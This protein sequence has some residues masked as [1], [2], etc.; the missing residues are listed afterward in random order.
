[1][2]LRLE[3]SY[4]GHDGIVG[5]LVNNELDDFCV[6]LEHAYDSGHGDGSYCPKLP[7]G[8]YECQLG[9]HRLHDGIPF[10][11]YEIL[12]VTGHDNILFHAGNYNKDS[13]GCV[14]V[15]EKQVLQQNGDIMVTNSRETFK[16]FM[17]YLKNV[18][19][20]TLIVVDLK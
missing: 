17:E 12:G 20:F 4:F 19:K 3:R 1:M 8:T 7:E 9:T 10:Q 18:E 16:K 15:G 6:T 14:L 13:D 5:F 2:I 11:T